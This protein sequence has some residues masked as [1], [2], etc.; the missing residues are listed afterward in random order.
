MAVSYEF[1]VTG[2]VLQL[3]RPLCKYLQIQ[4]KGHP[5]K[6]PTLRH[7]CALLVCATLQFSTRA[8]Q[9]IFAKGAPLT[10]TV[11]RTN[12]EE[13]LFMTGFGT[14]R[15]ALASLKE[16]KIDHAEVDESISTNRIPTFT[17]F[18]AQLSAQSW[19]TGLEQIPA[20]VI[21]TGILRY[22]PYVSFRCADDYEVNVYG[23]LAHPAGIEV[24]VY[25]KLLA[26]P[27]AKDNCIKLVTATMRRRDDQ[28]KI[29][30]LNTEK[31]QQVLDGLTFEI[32]PPNDP[33][34]Y[35]GWWISVY[36][37]AKINT[38]RASE[39][40]MKRISVSKL[41]LSRQ[42]QVIASWTKEDADK[43]RPYYPPTTQATSTPPGN[44]SSTTASYV[45]PASASSSYSGGGRVYVR[46]YWRKDGTY[47][48]AHTRSA[49]HR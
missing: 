27:L 40:E 3:W 18:L 15:F 36:D 16:I 19:A 22:V 28:V 35:Q 43:A 5:L 46:E 49:P 13:V 30:K 20:T 45:R 31:D 24:G 33:D 26:D 12:N 41:E 25:R 42:A 38:S 37:E 9:L 6:L 7:L 14:M 48:Q 23:D 21:E 47:V 32:T 29:S 17:N 8:D 10:G 1:L 2:N 44:S 34:A 39:E 4:Q 11:L